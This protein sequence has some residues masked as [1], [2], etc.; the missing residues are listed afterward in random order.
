MLNVG[1]S[2]QYEKLPFWVN[3]IDSAWSSFSEVEAKKNGPA[4]R[5]EVECIPLSELL[6]Q[7]GI[8]YY[9]KVDIEGA[10]HLAVSSLTP[11]IAPSVSV[12]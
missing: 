10:D 2:G 3:E 11:D 8:P 5:L 7:Y 1:I 6:K 4:R 12:R 9:V